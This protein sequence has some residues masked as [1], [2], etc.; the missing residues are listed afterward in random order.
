[1]LNIEFLVLLVG[2]L[3]LGMVLNYKFLLNILILLGGSLV[4]LTVMLLG[5]NLLFGLVCMLV[6]VGGMLLLFMYVSTMLGIWE[7]ALAGSYFFLFLIILVGYD[8]MRYDLIVDG[9]EV[10]FSLYDSNYIYIM[11]GRFF[12]RVCLLLV[13][14]LLG[15]KFRGNNI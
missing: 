3:G 14:N 9:R 8:A 1:M 5:G 4:L 13:I 12:L 15:R 2:V 11:C 7:E 6:Y 10:I